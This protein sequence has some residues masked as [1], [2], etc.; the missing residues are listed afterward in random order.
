MDRKTRTARCDDLLDQFRGQTRADLDALNE[1]NKLLAPQVWTGSITLTR[2]AARIVGEAPQAAPL[3]KLLDSS[4]FF[5]NSE[6]QQVTRSGAVEA[7][8]IRT[9]RRP[10]P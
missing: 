5:Q 1:L 3:L 8:Q 6:F 2:D 7:F 10:Q 4:P 9:T